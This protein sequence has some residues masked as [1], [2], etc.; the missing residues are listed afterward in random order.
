MRSGLSFR[1]VKIQTRLLLIF[2]SIG[3]GIIL[4]ISLIGYE[5]AKHI[6]QTGLYKELAVIRETRKRHLQEFIQENLM[7]LQTLSRVMDVRLLYDELFRYHQDLEIGPGDAYDVETE[8]FRQI[9]EE[10]G[11]VLSEYIAM[12]GYEDMYLLCA[13]HGHVMY[14]TGR[15]DDLGSNLQAGPYRDSPLTA[16]WQKVVDTQQVAMQD[17]QP[18]QP[19]GGNPAAFIGT[20]L[21]GDEG[22]MIGVLALQIS[23]AQV[24]DIMRQREGLGET[25]ESYLV[26]DDYLMRSDAYLDPHQRSVVG[27]FLNPDSG[28]VTT[29]AVQQALAGASGEG[30]VEDYRGVRV[31]SA[32]S[33][34][35]VFRG[36][37]WAL[38]VEIDEAEAFAHV[39]ELRTTMLAWSVGLIIIVVAGAVW[40]SRTITGP[41]HN[42]ATIAEHIARGE[43]DVDIAVTSRDEIGQTLR[44]MQGMVAYIQDVASV[45]ERVA[46]EDLQV[47]VTP[48][49]DR[50][51]LNQ[52]LLTMV[53]NLHEMVRKQ[54]QAMADI[55]QSNVVMRQQ[56][57]I[58]DG[59]SQLSVELAG[60]A[61]L[62]EVCRKALTFTARYVNAGQGVLYV[63]DQAAEELTLQASYA[64]IERDAASRAYRL[65][66]GTVG[67]AAFERQPIVVKHPDPET[68]TITTG[69]VQAPA[70]Q[71][72]TLPLV[73]EDELYG[74]LEL[75]FFVELTAS[76]REFVQEAVRVTATAVFSTA[77][78]ERVQDLL[79]AS[80]ESAAQA[81]EA[82]ELARQQAEDARNANILLEEKQQELEQ[83]SEELRQMT[84]QLEERE[85]E[86]QQQ[87]EELRQQNEQL[88]LS[89]QA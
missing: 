65:G 30:I 59:V 38:L 6:M 37:R 56:N 13:A 62:H 32:Y 15:R 4:A 77:Q 46:A 68:H 87:Q 67:Q 29:R 63:Y 70:L 81:E 75:A 19:A 51:V 71:T 40:V 72:Y 21:L 43:L 61:S 55:E 35:E 78:R 1:N 16:L 41:I 14:T 10:Y 22:A 8:R 57:W 18:Y 45:A 44:A 88:R 80:Q 52:A 53:A 82:T 24:N 64:F 12:H 7:D 26:G 83:Q 31:L 36:I 66:E 28:S 50:D 74:V 9:A 48:K 23:I 47:T 69:T 27:S 85:Q 84:A 34:V 2:V 58:K 39:Y 25:G 76:V 60:E 42:I 89:Q 79:R 73:Y 11:A 3:I 33:P 54:R 17:F 49:S 20:P 86:L 5:T